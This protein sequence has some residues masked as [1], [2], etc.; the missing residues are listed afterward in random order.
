MQ[1]SARAPRCTVLLSIPCQSANV[2]PEAHNSLFTGPAILTPAD[3][4][5]QEASWHSTTIPC[6]SHVAGSRAGRS[7]CTCNNSQRASGSTSWDGARNAGGCGARPSASSGRHA[8]WRV[9]RWRE[10]AAPPGETPPASPR[11]VWNASARQGIAY[12]LKGLPLAS[13]LSSAASAAAAA[14]ATNALFG[15]R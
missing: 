2:C 9:R 4:H 8:G 1:F 12:N 3:P 5:S 7:V 15:R 6:P 13:G 11:S 10:A 14:V